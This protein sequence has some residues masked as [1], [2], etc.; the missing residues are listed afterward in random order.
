MDDLT[1]MAAE[2]DRLEPNPSARPP[3]IRQRPLW[4]WPAAAALALCLVA[5]W[6]RA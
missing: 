1:A 4:M 2:L 5:A 3:L 6:R